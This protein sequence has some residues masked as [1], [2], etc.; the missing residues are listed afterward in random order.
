MKAAVLVLHG[1]KVTS[2][3]PATRWQL[4]SVRMW[5]FTWS[6]RRA[7][8]DTAVL[9][10]QYRYRGWNGAEESP[11]RDARWALAQIRDR[12]GDVPVTLV[13]HSMG[14]RTAA[15]V[16]DDPN[17]V[18]VV[19]LAPWW[20]SGNETKAMRAEQSVLVVHGS[21]DRWTD[22]ALSKAATDAALVR[23]VRARYVSMKRAGHFML[24]SPWT[25]SKLVRDFV[26]DQSPSTCAT[27]T[28]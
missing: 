12:F 4:S 23:G 14:G 6:L 21:A 15:A 20:P 11:V 17:V 18:A 28:R 13:G 24:R 8:T 26:V 9:Q 25:W 19:A 16:A 22:P 7:L 3:D 1:G 5:P 2:H 27:K 10:L